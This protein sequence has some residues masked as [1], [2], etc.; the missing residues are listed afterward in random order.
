MKKLE[1]HK[2]ILK[3]HEF[4][5]INLNNVQSFYAVEEYA[6]TNLLVKVQEMGGLSEKAARYIFSQL[7]SAVEQCHKNGICHRNLN[8]MNI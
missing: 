5:Q 6:S 1:P 4:T 2:H 7:V 3:V 8:L